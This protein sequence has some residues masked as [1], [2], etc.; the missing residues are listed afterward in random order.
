MRV[1]HRESE[2]RFLTP[3]DGGE[4][5]L[6]YAMRAPEVMDI[7]STY[8]PAADRGR[9]VG[10]VLVQAALDHARARS[11]RVIPSCWYVGTWVAA[12]PEYRDLLH[13]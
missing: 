3:T 2:G 4:A 1:E 7:E 9:G 5:V 8:V 6:W 11:W 12:H 10:G 13:R